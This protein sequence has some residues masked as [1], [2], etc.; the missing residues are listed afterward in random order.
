M[1]LEKPKHVMAP[2]PNGPHPPL[3]LQPAPPVPWAFAP[4]QSIPPPGNVL[5]SN[6]VS[7][8]KAQTGAL[9]RAQIA[10]VSPP[11]RATGRRQSLGAV[12]PASPSM[13]TTGS[14]RL[15]P[16]PAGR[17]LQRVLPVA[18]VNRMEMKH[19]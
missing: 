5:Y 18:P 15:H 3:N 11:K 4:T 10:T 8:T 17:P 2:V 9:F 7:P 12:F 13:T 16:P 19:A 14:M 1:L 6:F